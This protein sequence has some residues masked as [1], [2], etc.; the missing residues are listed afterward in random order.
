MSAG[1]L[2]APQLRVRGLSMRFPRALSNARTVWTQRDMLLVYI[3]GAEDMDR[4]EDAPL[5]HAPI[6]F[7]REFSPEFLRAEHTWS[8]KLGSMCTPVPGGRAVG[9]GEVAPL[10]GYAHESLHACLDALV[11]LERSG[12]LAWMLEGLAALCPRQTRA[13][14]AATTKVDRARSEIRARSESN[15][16]LE[17]TLSALDALFCASW[18]CAIDCLP[19]LRFGLETAAYTWLAHA[20]VLQGAGASPQAHASLGCG[21]THETS[22][23]SDRHRMVTLRVA[24]LVTAKDC[25]ELTDRVQRA[26]LEGTRSFKWKLGTWGDVHRELRAWKLVSD[27][28]SMSGAPGQETPPRL[29]L[30]LDANQSLNEASLDAIREGLSLLP[31]SFLEEPMPREDL[32][33]WLT[34]QRSRPTKG[35][36][37]T[38]APWLADIPFAIDESFASMVMASCRD[39]LALGEAAAWVARATRDKQVY[40]CLVLK[41]AMLGGAFPCMRAAEAASRPSTSTQTRLTEDRVPESIDASSPPLPVVITHTLDGPV[42]FAASARVAADWSARACRQG[43]AEGT[44]LDPGMAP[45]AGLPLASFDALG[46][47]YKQGRLRVTLPRFADDG[48]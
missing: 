19:A 33:A 32:M 36:V 10:P 35:P 41:P 8:E 20:R 42:G 25:D 18:G 16:E 27:A 44:A 48:E 23:I 47:V 24:K 30:R 22:A 34:A 9:I 39:G 37:E 43:S 12:S 4:S 7:L 28:L 45:H 14:H 6:A 26:W 29:S 21:A 11:Q 1:A 46:V 40:Q 38:D 5:L 2:S 13:E 3:G 17:E 31:L 15:G